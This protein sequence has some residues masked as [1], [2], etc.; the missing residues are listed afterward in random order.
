MIRD[1]YDFSQ[2]IKNPYYQKLNKNQSLT[3]SEALD[4]FDSLDVVPLDQMWG[5]WE[6]W[7]INTNHRFNGL[8]GFTNWYGKQFVDSETVH[9]LLFSDSQGNLFKVG[10]SIYS[11]KI[12]LNL[13][14]LKNKIFHPLL[15]NSMLLFKTESAQARL[16]MMEYRGKVSAAMIYDYLPINDSF[17]KIDRDTILGIMDFKIIPEPFFF[18]LERR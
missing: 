11:I 7:E 9:P 2:S 13:P 3:T 17:R 5:T 4:W 6:G 14:I 8:L 18:I 12:F 1:N 15:K 16:R 10:P